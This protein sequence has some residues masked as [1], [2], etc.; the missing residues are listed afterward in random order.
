MT[1][2]QAAPA[3]HAGVRMLRANTG[4]ELMHQAALADTRRAEHRDEPGPARLEHL[5]QQAVQ[6]LQLRGASDQRAAEAGHAPS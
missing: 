1:R 5:V 4:H 2:G 3:K 6:R